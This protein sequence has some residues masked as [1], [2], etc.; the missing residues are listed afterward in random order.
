MSRI[1]VHGVGAVS[2]AGW[3]VAALRDALQCGE[4]IPATPLSRPGWEK[5]LMVR[6][7]PPPTQRPIFLSHPRLRRSSAIT[8]HTVAAALEALGGDVAKFQTGEQRLGIVVCLMSGC[9]AYSRRFLEEVLKDPSTASPLVFPETVFNAPGSHLAAYLNATSASYT[10]VGDDAAFLQGL[11]VGAG[12]LA[13]GEVDG[14]VVVGAEESD[15]LVAD[16]LRLFARNAI[17][18]A[19]AGAVYLRREHAPSGIEMDAITDAFPYSSSRARCAAAQSVRTQLGGN[20]ATDLL[21]LGTTGVPAYDAAEL[22]AWR[23]WTGKRTAPKQFLG[24]A[25]TAATAWQCVAGCAALMNHEAGAALVSATGVSE[26]AIGARFR[27]TA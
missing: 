4:A 23:D 3:G 22:E 11:A 25:F 20:P 15:W 6:P 7:V 10:L 17:Q 24:E 27:R 5:P 26:Q 18:G 14:C 12:W 1:F 19:G 21:F 9:V 13:N 2:P 16:A 8:Q